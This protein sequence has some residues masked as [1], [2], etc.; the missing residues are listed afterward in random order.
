MV[1]MFP[2]RDSGA[3]LEN[4]SVGFPDDKD[5]EQA[6]AAQARPGNIRVLDV[7][8]V[9]ANDASIV[10]LKNNFPGPLQ[11]GAFSSRTNA[12]NYCEQQALSTG[13][14]SS[15]AILWRLLGLRVRHGGVPRTQANVT[16]DNLVNT[17]NDTNQ[18]S[19][20]R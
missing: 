10:A 4:S 19:I 8:A 18:H 6:S 12:I 3:S 17:K 20:V 1:V 15:S 5:H 2:Q 11:P 7:S 13:S 16:G 14:G 9:L